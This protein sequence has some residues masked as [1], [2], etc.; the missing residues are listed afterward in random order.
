MLADFLLDYIKYHASKGKAAWKFCYLSKDINI[1]KCIA[2][3]RVMVLPKCL[4][5]WFSIFYDIIL[6]KSLKSKMMET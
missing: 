1:Q 4:F 5:Y 3:V 2:N 6:K